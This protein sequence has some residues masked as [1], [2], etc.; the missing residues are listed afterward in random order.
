MY[1]KVLNQK[2]K[3]LL[4]KIKKT[5][6]PSNF[7]LAGGTALALQ[8]G[9]RKSIDL[10]WFSKKSFT[11][12]DL[13]NK[14]KTFG[15]LK[16]SEEEKGTLNCSLEGVKLSFFEYSY[17]TLFPLTEYD[18]NIKLADPRDI[19]CM[20]ID[21]ISTRGTKR[22]FIDL[23]F[24]ANKNSLRKAVDYYKRKYGKLALN[25][26]HSFRAMMYFIDADENE[27]PKMLVKCN[28]QKV[29]KY[30]LKEVPRILDEELKIKPK[31]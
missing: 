17:K 7:Y 1:Q 20:K 11:V 2:T 26:Q 3:R 23:Y 25:L 16:I 29:K 10:D 6:I 31:K 13:K 30:F 21:A 27:M 19:A 4:E 28:W 9:H 5:K 14:L 18:K 8:I 24:L 22:D 15:K 12:K